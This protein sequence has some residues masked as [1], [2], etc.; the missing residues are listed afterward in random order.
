MGTTFKQPGDVITLTAPTGGVVSGQAYLIGGLF[1]VAMSTAAVGVA[2]EAAV[3]GVFALPK[4]ASQAWAEG[5]RVYWDVANSRLDSD[6]TLG[7]CVGVATVVVGSGSTETTGTV[8]L[9]E[10]TTPA[11]R[12]VRKRFSVA[13]V[14]AGATLVPATPGQKIRMVDASAI[15]VGGAASAVTTVD[16]LATLTTSRKLV[17]FAQASLT[18]STLLRAGATGGAILAD[19]ASFTANDVNTAVTVGITGSS[20]ATA[21]SIDISFTYALEPG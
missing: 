6:D 19:G 12:T 13:Q 11:L 1:V 9:N 20:V 15:A 16:I 21:T 7:P 8:K 10:A 18:Q 2:F 5:Q 3:T 14:N 17:A 4:T